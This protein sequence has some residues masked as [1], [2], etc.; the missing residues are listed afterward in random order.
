MV[1]I[2]EPIRMM[3]VVEQAPDTIDRAIAKLGP[4]RRSL[5]NEWVRLA[6]YDPNSRKIKLYSKSG[7]TDFDFPPYLSVPSAPRSEDIFVGCT[8]S[9]PVHLLVRGGLN[10]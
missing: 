10:G 9:I 6:S 7:W 8:E 5:D 4:L 3:F 2:H 1:E